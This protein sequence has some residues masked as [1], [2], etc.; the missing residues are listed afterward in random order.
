MLYSTHN[1]ALVYKGIHAHFITSTIQLTINNNF[2]KAL[3]AIEFMMECF[4]QYPS[5]TKEDN[6]YFHKRVAT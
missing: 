2:T 4:S 3:V 1:C 5:T 6:E